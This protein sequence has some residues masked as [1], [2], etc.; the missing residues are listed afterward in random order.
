M[1]PY[2]SICCLMCTFMSDHTQ[3]SR[4]NTFGN[5]IKVTHSTKIKILDPIVVHY[6]WF[7]GIIYYSG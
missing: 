3:N 1:H 4:E 6:N 7:T 5:K 2:Y